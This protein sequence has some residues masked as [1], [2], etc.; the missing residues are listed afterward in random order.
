MRKLLSVLVLAVA[1]VIPPAALAAP[2]LAGQIPHTC[3]VHVSGNVG[4]GTSKVWITSYSG[5]PS[6]YPLVY[7]RT[8]CIYLHVIGTFWYNGPT[9]KGLGSSSSNY[10]G[11]TCNQYPHPSVTQVWAWENGGSGWAGRRLF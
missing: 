10:S 7:N 6:G 5:C 11:V 4:L 2:S 8:Q 9:R 1:A 3:T